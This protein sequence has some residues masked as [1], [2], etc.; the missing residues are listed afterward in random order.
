MGVL[1]IV[2]WKNTASILQAGT[3]RSN[4]SISNNRPNLATCPGSCVLQC[5]HNITWA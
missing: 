2:F 3:N 5:C 1:P 4:G